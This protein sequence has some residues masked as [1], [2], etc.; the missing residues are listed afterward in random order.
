[1]KQF[2]A[3][4]ML[5]V[6]IISCDSSKKKGETSQS[7]IH[8]AIA[9]EVLHV[10][11]YSYI[12]VQENGQELWVAAPTTP[13]E[14]G[15]TYY[16]GKAME[17]NNFESKD[18]NKTFETVYFVERI[19][20]NPELATMPL[21]ENPHPINPEATKPVIEKKEVKV[22]TSSN[23]ISIATLFEKKDT[24]NNQIVTLKGE[25]TKYNPGIM[26]MNWLHLQDGTDYNGEFDITVTTKEEVNKGDIVTIKGKVTLNKD[27]GAG[28]QYD[29]IIE[30]A[31][32]IK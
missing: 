22:E 20:D 10:K 31:T 29:V 26:N 1:M 30:N 25:V 18:L 4:L 16:Y 15:K 17:M 11:E 3:L 9:Q 2:I 28:Y 7:G 32:V 5:F 21:T 24:Y 23:G 13:I 6:V 19:S 12:R 27:F 14:I 8:K